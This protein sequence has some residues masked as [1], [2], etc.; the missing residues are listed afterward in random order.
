VPAYTA[1]DL[2][3]GWRI[4]PGLELSLVGQNLFDPQHA[5]FGAAPGR[6]EYRRAVFAKLVWTR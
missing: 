1:V 4:N 5:E 2:R 3:F 6:S